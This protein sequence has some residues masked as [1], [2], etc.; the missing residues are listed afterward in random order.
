MLSRSD[1]Y[2]ASR[3]EGGIVHEDETDL[4]AANIEFSRLQGEWLSAGRLDWVIALG[5]VAV[6]LPTGLFLYDKLPVNKSPTGWLAVSAATVIMPLLMMKL[7]GYWQQHRASKKIVETLTGNGCVPTGIFDDLKE[8]DKRILQSVIL[9]AIPLL[10]KASITMSD[11]VAT[12]TSSRDKAILRLYAAVIF[13]LF[14]GLGLLEVRDRRIAA[15]S[16]HAAAMLHCIALGLRENTTL[17]TNWRVKN[18]ADPAFR[19]A[20]NFISEAEENRR[21]MTRAAVWTPVRKDVQASLV[22]LKAVRNGV[23]EV[24]VRW[25]YSWNNYNWVGGTQEPADRSPEAC[26][27]RE[28]HEELGLDRSGWLS[29][30]SIGS[31]TSGPIKSV[32]LGVYSTWCYSVF[33]LNGRSIS[34]TTL[35][36]ELRRILQPTAEFEIFTDELRATKVRW[37]K[38][39]DIASQPD[40]GEY[41][42]ELSQFL[43]ARFGSI[44]PTFGFDLGDV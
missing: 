34:R 44:V 26:A 42:T 5:I 22:I 9:L 7:R 21:V 43:L 37:V 20:F 23:E 14:E 12:Q 30:D 18:V 4:Q 28:V 35:P 38:W 36:V 17:L 1:R 39:N 2:I 24:L 13:D 41:G 31:V 33:V 25:S 29:M 19:R 8:S 3:L 40:F 6:T 10:P 16:E 27:W 32:R 15:V 11:L